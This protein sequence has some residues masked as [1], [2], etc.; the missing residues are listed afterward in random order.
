MDQN[1]CITY[2]TSTRLRYEA[3]YGGPRYGNKF[4]QIQA[5]FYQ[6]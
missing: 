6:N 4:L 1:I 5:D 2:K 3:Q